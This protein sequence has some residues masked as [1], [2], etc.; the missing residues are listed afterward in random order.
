MA[1]RN[2]LDLKYF[3]CPTSDY[4]IPFCGGNRVLIPFETEEP[5]SLTIDG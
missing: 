4:D 3:M 1:L 2:L 5:S